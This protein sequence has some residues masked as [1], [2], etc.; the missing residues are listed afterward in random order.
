MT[1]ETLVIIIVFC[2][3]CCYLVYRWQEAAVDSAI[4]PV[5]EPYPVPESVVKD[6][7]DNIDNWNAK[8]GDKI[9]YKP[10]AGP[11]TESQVEQIKETAVIPQAVWPFPG[12]PKP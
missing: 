12:G 10:D 4:P 5:P 11:L 7:L 2:L 9:W 1:I 8:V 6:S 3:F